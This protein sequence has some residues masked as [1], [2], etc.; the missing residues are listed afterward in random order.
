MKPAYSRSLFFVAI[1]IA[2]LAACNGGSSDGGSA[3]TTN[4]SATPPLPV[5]PGTLGDGRMPEIVEAI[6][7]RNDLPAL[8]AIIVSDGQI[9]DQGASGLRAID[10]E[11]AVTTA[12]NGTW[13]PSPRL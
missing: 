8:A 13:D 6:R 3:S 2:C 11:A 10:A 1:S 9:T 12:T 4:G 5:E 7:A